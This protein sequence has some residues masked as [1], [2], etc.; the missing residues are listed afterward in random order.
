MC[1]VGRKPVLDNAMTFRV[2]KTFCRE[3]RWWQVIAAAVM[4]DHFHALVRPLYARDAPITQFSAGLKRFVRRQTNAD[5]KWQD[6]VFDR[7]LRR[8][9]FAESKWLYMRE[10]PVRAGL[11]NHWEDW[12][13][14]IGYTEL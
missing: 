11:V 6:G 1:V 12:A 13:Y 4:P 8:E 5:W 2:I 7:V 9:E 10:N 3:N 14:P